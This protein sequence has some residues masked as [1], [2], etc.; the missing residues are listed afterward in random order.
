MKKIFLL[1]ALT[2]I[3]MSC[4][5]DEQKISEFADS[6]TA[7][8]AFLSG[9]I[10]DSASAFTEDTIFFNLLPAVQFPL[11]EYDH[12]EIVVLH[13]GKKTTWTRNMVNM[14]HIPAPSV[15]GEK[16]MGSWKGV[17]PE[18]LQIFIWMIESPTAKASHFWGLD[19][20]EKWREYMAK[21][22]H[23]EVSQELA[24]DMCKPISPLYELMKLK[25]NKKSSL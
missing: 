22:F 7:F 17:T 3:M 11:A 24:A 6:K 25:G 10:T 14:W 23:I 9:T 5:S 21:N 16:A 20:P 8:A 12:D 4:K 1:L 18:S 2:A 15:A 19:S 13:N